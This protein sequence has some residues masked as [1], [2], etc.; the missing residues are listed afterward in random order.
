MK[1]INNVKKLQPRT[2]KNKE[3]N[4]NVSSLKFGN[5][6]IQVLKKCK[7]SE[8]QIDAVKKYLLKHF[9]GIGKIWVR[10]ALDFPETKKPLEVRMGKGKGNIYKYS[11]KIKAGTVI[12]EVASLDPNAINILNASI[13]KIGITC[14]VIKKHD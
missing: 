1:N 11:T 13:K 4:I 10:K 6:G 8:N 5:L 2:F 3:T 12:F 7:L 9:K 14:K